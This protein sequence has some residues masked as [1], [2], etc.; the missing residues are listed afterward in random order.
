[1]NIP[2]IDLDILRSEFGQLERQGTPYGYGAKAE[3]SRNPNTGEKYN[4]RSNGHLST[5]LSTIDHLDCSGFIR[6]ALYRASNH[7]LSLPDGSQQQ[8][9]WCEA[10]SHDSGLHQVVD[11][12][13]TNAYLTPERL[14]IAFIKPYTNGCGEIGH[15]W[16]LSQLDDDAAEETMECYGGHGVGSRPWNSSILKREVFSIYELP[17]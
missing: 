10:R 11:Y 9:Q 13:D 17:V 3:G 15:V 7:A 12:A 5:N 6:Y 16:L 14:F 1:M 4:A 2:T 8:R